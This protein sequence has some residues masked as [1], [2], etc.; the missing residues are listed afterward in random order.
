MAEIQ[1]LQDIA[2]EAIGSATV[3]NAKRNRYWKAWEGHCRLYQMDSSGKPPPN[4]SNMLLTFAVA[5]REDWFGL[6]NQVKVQ[7]VSK[8]LLAVGQK[9]VLDGH[10][11]PR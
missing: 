11:D 3:G 1:R 8:A 10:Q 9:Y 7:S 5:V 2:W 6:G 4:T